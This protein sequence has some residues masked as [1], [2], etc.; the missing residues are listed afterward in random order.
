MDEKTQAMLRAPFPPALIGK[1]PQG[2]CRLCS[3]SARR[4]CDDH[5]KIR[6]NGCGQYMTSAHIH[7]DFVGHADTTDRFLAVDP[8]WTWEPVA[9]GDDGLPRLDANN[10][11]WIRLTIAGVT[12]L[13]YGDAQGKS[14]PN[15][16]K[17][18]I[19]DALRNAGMRFGVGLDMWRKEGTG[20]IDVRPPTH[21]PA[22]DVPADKWVEEFEERLNQSMTRDALA[23][24]WQELVAAFKD[25]L[26]T[27]TQANKFKDLIGE[28]GEAL[29]EESA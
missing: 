6:C 5:N 16:V 28:R 17:E 29:A 18:C 7:L 11:L 19:G 25:G 9:F 1:K 3:Q 14:G 24:R 12:R 2:T 26:V 23:D 13:G 4:V 10:G 21:V 8:E 27:E 22:A 20:V 15:A